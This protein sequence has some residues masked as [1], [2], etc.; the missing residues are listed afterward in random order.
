MFHLLCVCPLPLE[1]PSPKLPILC[2]GG[3]LNPT[4]SI[5]NNFG[6]ILVKFQWKTII[7]EMLC[8]RKRLSEVSQ[9]SASSG[10]REPRHRGSRT[11]RDGQL[12]RYCHNGTYL[13]LQAPMYPP[14]RIVHVIRSHPKDSRSVGHDNS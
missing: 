6:L 7:A 14:G 4:H 5:I 2:R 8:H 13:T 10:T 1:R 3:T 11:G 9:S 12:G